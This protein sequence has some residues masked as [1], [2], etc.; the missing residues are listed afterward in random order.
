MVVR[1]FVKAL[2]Q[3]VIEQKIPEIASAPRKLSETSA[4]PYSRPTYEAPK[5]IFNK[6]PCDNDFEV[7]FAKFLQMA[8]DVVK[9]SKLPKK[10]GFT[11]EYTDSVANLR[12]YEPDFVAVLDDGT[13][14]LIETKGREDPMC[15]TRIARQLCGVNMLVIWRQLDGNTLRWD[16]AIS[17]IWSLIHFQT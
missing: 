11:I 10:F 17:L 16:N 14:Y 4:F 13:H 12:Y 3:I 6:V 15:H 2:R 5:C 1:T 8:R 9:F 7:E